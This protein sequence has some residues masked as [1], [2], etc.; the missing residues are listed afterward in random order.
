M[1]S[2]VR[3]DHERLGSIRGLQVELIAALDAS[4]EEGHVLRQSGSKRC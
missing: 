2:K 4:S 1:S 3:R